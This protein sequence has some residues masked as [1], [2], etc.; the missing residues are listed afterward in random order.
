MVSMV[1]CKYFEYI[2]AHIGIDLCDNYV[3]RDRNYLYYLMILKIQRMFLVITNIFFANLLR[4][5]NFRL[6][7]KI[8]IYWPK[9]NASHAPSF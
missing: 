2:L 7:I 8:N 9:A 6:I 4:L 1:R 3:I 5:N